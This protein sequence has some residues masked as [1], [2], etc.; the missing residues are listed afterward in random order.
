MPRNDNHGLCGTAARGVFSEIDLREEAMAINKKAVRSVLDKAI[1]AKRSA[2]TA[3]ECKK[4]CAAYG[5]PLPRDG[6]AASADKAAALAKRLGFPVVMKIQSEDILHKTD[7]G[8][9]IVGVNSAAD[10]KKA[11]NTILKNAR[12]YVKRHAWRPGA[13]DAVVRRRAGSAVGAV[14]SQLASWS[15]S[16]SAACWSDHDDI[17]FRSAAPKSDALGMWHSGADPV[18]R[19]RRR[20]RS[21]K[22]ATN[23]NVSSS[24]PTFRRSR[25]WT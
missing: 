9:V 21:P 7:A 13:E 8:G 19:A 4:I 5:I 3:E 18:G 15:P 14:P 16:V 17:T 24:C 23:Q 25:R 11:Y 1:K 20:S 2:L 22:V 6:L 10:A 12:A